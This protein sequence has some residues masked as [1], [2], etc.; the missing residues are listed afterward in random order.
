MSQGLR[1]RAATHEDSDLLLG[2]RNDPHTRMASQH[3]TEVQ[4]D[5]HLKWLES[6]LRDEKRILMVAEEETIP[7]GTV[8][9]D[10][11]DGVYVLSWTVAP[12]ARGRGVG[13][14]MVALF[15]SQLPGAVRAEVKKEN[16]ASVRIAEFAGLQFVREDR[17]VLLYKRGNVSGSKPQV[18]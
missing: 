8:R 13:K 9:A 2:W 5:E 4:R 16:Q 3:T 10:L 14:A 7:V 1:L 17:G 15:L 6:S 11:K 12:G 18:R